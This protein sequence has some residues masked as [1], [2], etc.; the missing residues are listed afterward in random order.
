MGARAAQ[1]RLIS[2]A[3][4]RPEDSKRAGSVWATSAST[5]LQG[6]GA[7]EMAMAAATPGEECDS[8]APGASDSLPRCLAG[9]ARVVNKAHFLYLQQLTQERGRGRCGYVGTAGGLYCEVPQYRAC[10]GI[11]RACRDVLPTR[12]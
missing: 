10:P 9:L 4:A 7:S 3:G 2:L 5:K 6:C 11:E 1:A 8:C 12:P